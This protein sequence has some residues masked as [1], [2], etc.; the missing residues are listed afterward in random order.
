MTMLDKIVPALEMLGQGM[1]G[2]FVVLGI[3]ALVV[4]A[5]QK[6]DSKKK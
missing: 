3:I 5:L 2:I 1:A 4:K 6:L